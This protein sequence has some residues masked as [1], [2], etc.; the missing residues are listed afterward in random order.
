[1]VEDR[2]KGADGGSTRW[3]GVVSTMSPVTCATCV[4][5]FGLAMVKVVSG[6]AEMMAAVRIPWENLDPGDLNRPLTKTEKNRLKRRKQKE[7]RRAAAAAA[8]QQQQQQ[9]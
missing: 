2:P 4:L 8:R 7:K 3:G 6:L 9:E 1:D 5:G